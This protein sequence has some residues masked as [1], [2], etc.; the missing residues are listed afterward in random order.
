MINNTSISI[1]IYYFWITVEITCTCFTL[2]KVFLNIFIQI[3]DP[4]FFFQL[5]AMF[6]LVN[7]I[8]ELPLMTEGKRGYSRGH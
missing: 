7:V 4:P 6:S 2:I 8:T 3:K 1:I 5:L